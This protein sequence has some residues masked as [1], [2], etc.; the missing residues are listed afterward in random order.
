MG[1]GDTRT[2]MIQQL[3]MNN[4]NITKRVWAIQMRS[5]QVEASLIGVRSFPPL[6]ETADDY[7]LD[8]GLFFGCHEKEELQAVISIQTKHTRLLITRLMVDPEHFRK[9]IGT[10]LINYV[11]TLYKDCTQLE[12]STAT[13][14]TPAVQAYLK[15]GFV[16]TEEHVTPEG[17]S[18][19]TFVKNI[20]FGKNN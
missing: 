9:G 2:R 15:N 16:L 8:S 20:Y 1:Y 12:V 11:S 4:P 14:N 18:I 19:V 3:N 7:K 6:Q 13:L 10:S 5:Y 17:I